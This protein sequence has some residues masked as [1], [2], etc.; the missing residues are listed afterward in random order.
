M[1]GKES[2]AMPGFHDDR[3]LQ[4]GGYSARGTRKLSV[5]TQVENAATHLLAV[6]SLASLSRDA[7]LHG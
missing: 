3:T 4:V 1:R 2:V 6:D 5:G 7:H